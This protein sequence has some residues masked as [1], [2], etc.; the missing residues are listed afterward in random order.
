MPRQCVDSW[1]RWRPVSLMWE[2]KINKQRRL[3]LC[4]RCRDDKSAVIRSVISMI[5]LH[6]NNGLRKWQRWGLTVKRRWEGWGTKLH[7]ASGQGLATR[8]DHFLCRFVKTFGKC[9]TSRRGV[10]NS[11]SL[12]LSHPLQVLASSGT[13]SQLFHWN[14]L[15]VSTFLE[16]FTS[17]SSYVFQSLWLHPG[18]LSAVDQGVSCFSQF[19][20]IEGREIVN[21]WFCSTQKKVFVVC[22]RKVN[23]RKKD[24]CP[25]PNQKN[26]PKIKIPSANP[27]QG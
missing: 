5:S 23:C 18:T 20:P 2:I 25:L 12:S 7:A 24:D 8:G 4:R 6:A 19:T 9:E 15:W 14:L 17:P 26:T 3:T 11:P 21:V 16:M 1:E 10:V 22:G 27:T 13:R